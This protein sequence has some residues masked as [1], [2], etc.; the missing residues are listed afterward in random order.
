MSPRN[1]ALG[2]CEFGGGH[3]VGDVAAVAGMSDA[4]RNARPFRLVGYGT[5]SVHQDILRLLHA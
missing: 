5:T 1:G 4:S 2:L 3:G